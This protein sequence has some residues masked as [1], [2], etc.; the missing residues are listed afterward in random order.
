[1]AFP[2][3]YGKRKAIKYGTVFPG[4][5]LTDFPKLFQITADLD[6]KSELT[7]GGGLALT[8][9]DGTT[10]VSFGLYPTSVPSLGTLL[11]RAKFAL[12]AGAS[13]GDT[14]GY[15]YYDHAQ[16]TTEDKPGTVSNSYILFAPLEEDPSGSAPQMLDWVTN[17]LLGTTQG[18]MSSGALVAGAVGNGLNFDTFSSQFAQFSGGAQPS[19]YTWEVWAASTGQSGIASVQEASVASIHDREIGFNGA[20]Q[21]EA[22][23]FD[24]ATK[25]ATG[26]TTLSSGVLYL[27]GS[28]YDGTSLRVFVNG[29]QDGSSLAGDPYGAYLSPVS[30]IA[31]AA[32]ISANNLNGIGDEVRFSSVARSADWLAYAWADDK[33]NA[34]TFSLGTEETS[35]GGGAAA[36]PLLYSVGQDEILAVWES[37]GIF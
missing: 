34:A 37:I 10:P 14:L 7:S 15:L 21:A 19:R 17:S 11:L 5:N 32:G 35:G 8:L 18:S 31:K 24:G 9:A 27:I 3:G 6:I 16:T 12:A 4:S 28:S 30:L 29:A 26:A 22:Y 25:T 20:F 23:H 1:M 13:T 36:F 2:N 33:N